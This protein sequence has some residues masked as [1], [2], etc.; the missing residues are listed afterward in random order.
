MTTVSIIICTYN[1]QQLLTNCLGG[2]VAQ[3]EPFIDRTEVIVVDNNSKDGTAELVGTY[4]ARYSWLRYVR[5]SQQGLSHARNRGATVAIGSYLCFLDDDA[6][7]SPAY[8]ASIHQVIEE[9]RPDIFGGP[10]YPYYTST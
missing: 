1:R 4:C 6:K 5:E 10:V 9:H 3:M 2:L 8:L 7:P